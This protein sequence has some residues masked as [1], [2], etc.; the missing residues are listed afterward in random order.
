M[1]KDVFFG[2]IAKK[3]IPLELNKLFL[4]FLNINKYMMCR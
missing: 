3:K 2:V 1:D 4:Q